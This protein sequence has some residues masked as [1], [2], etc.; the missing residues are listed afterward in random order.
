MKKFFKKVLMVIVEWF[1]SLPKFAQI[2]YYSVSSMLYSSLTTA[3]LAD[4]GEL[5][6][7]NEYGALFLLAFVGFLSTTFNLLQYRLTKFGEELKIIEV[8]K[9]RLNK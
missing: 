3:I 8:E 9:Y 6:V 2:G 1:T 4:L 5:K 7:E